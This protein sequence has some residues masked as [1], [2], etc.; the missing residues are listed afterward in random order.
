MNDLEELQSQE[1]ES[2][3]DLLAD[4][5]AMFEEDDEKMA[6]E[7]DW[8]FL[9]DFLEVLL[10]SYIPI[11]LYNSPPLRPLFGVLKG[12]GGYKIISFSNE[13]FTIS[14]G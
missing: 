12:G 5:D 2:D 11:I 4:L 8:L 1:E 3:A 6:E 7:N 13:K 14:E 9:F 10:I